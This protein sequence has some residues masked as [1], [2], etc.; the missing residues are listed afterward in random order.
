MNKEELIG[1]MMLNKVVIR[2]SNGISF[3]PSRINKPMRC[4]LAKLVAE[5][6]RNVGSF[7]FFFGDC[8]NPDLSKDVS[9]LFRGKPRVL[10]VIE[11]LRVPAS[12][13]K[14]QHNKI[15]IILNSI[16]D[17][18]VQRAVKFSEVANKDPE[19]K[20]SKVALFALF[21]YRERLH[22]AGIHVSSVF[23]GKDFAF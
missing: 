19:E 12:L 10:H 4:G 20:I 7:N 17:D 21:D 18:D 6:V 13:P 1:A 9:M 14:P 3:H 5:E 11:R 16:K 15:A 22:N 8:Q 23:Q 2:T